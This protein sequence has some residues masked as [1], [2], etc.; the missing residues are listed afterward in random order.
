MNRLSNG[1]KIVL[2]CVV[3]TAV[4]VGLAWLIS[5]VPWTESHAFRLSVVSIALVCAVIDLIH[6]LL[7]DSVKEKSGVK[8]AARIVKVIH[9]IAWVCYG[10]THI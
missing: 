7:K 5:Y 2:W 1:W 4:S 10:A 8:S 6:T 9:W 3:G